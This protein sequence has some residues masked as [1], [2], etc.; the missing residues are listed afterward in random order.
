[1]CHCTLSNHGCFDFFPHLLVVL[2]SVWLIGT[3]VTLIFSFFFGRMLIWWNTWC[4]I[5][6]ERICRR[7]GA[8][9][10]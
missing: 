9:R 10:A 8:R 6:R 5:D 2:F 3:M 4:S 7:C 1:M